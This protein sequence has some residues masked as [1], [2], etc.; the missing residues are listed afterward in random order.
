MLSK[1]ISTV[2][3]FLNRLKDDDISAYSAQAA[4]FIILSSVPFILLLLT[5]LKYTP[6]TEDMFTEFLLNILPDSLDSFV[7]S[8]IRQL[9]SSAS[10]TVISITAI[11]TLWS[12]GKGI[13]SII[14]GMNS[15][16]HTTETRNYFVLR[17]VSTIYTVLFLIAIILML[18]ILVFGNYLYEFLGTHAP[19]I[20][21]FL[22]VFINDKDII[23]IL[24]L[25][26]FFICVYK[27][28]PDKNY[29][30]FNHLPG[31]IFSALSWYGFS[32][33][34]SIYVDNYSKITFMYGSLSTV[35]ILM[36]WL[37]F[38]MYLM[39]IGGEINVIFKPNIDKLHKHLSAKYHNL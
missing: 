22:G 32:Y 9:Y 3:L 6:L 35:A 36:L 37:Y 18:A 34:F 26:L 33:I 28:A 10:G 39:F 13:L 1:I 14:R 29:T 31:S 15:I 21:E 12:A 19:L 27:I 38:C 7:A 25:I 24:F 11:A 4:F 16:H 20:H 30:V 17:A 2:R 8:L 5:I 23:S